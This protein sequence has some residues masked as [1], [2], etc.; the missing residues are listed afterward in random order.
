MKLT[1]IGESVA[2]PE[3]CWP[4]HRKVGTKPGTGKNAG[5]QVNDCEKI[6]E[7]SVAE[8]G[9]KNMYAEFSGYGNYMQGRAVNVF[10]T[11]GL[12]IVSK[13]YTEDDDI[14]TYVVK[15]DRQSIEKAGEYLER[16]AE[17]FG[18][19][20]FV[21]SGVT[22]N[23][24]K[25]QDLS[26]VSTEKLK[27]YL[28]KQGQQQGSGEGGQVKRVQA[29]LQR[30]SQ[31]VGE[32]YQFKGP[33][34]FDVDHMHGGRGINLPVADTRD[35]LQKPYEYYG[36]YKEWYR[37]VNRVNS[38]LLDDNAEYTTTAGGKTISINGKDFAAWSNRN[39]NGRI[40]IGIAKKHSGQG[41]AEMVGYNQGK[42]QALSFTGRKPVAKKNPNPFDKSPE[43]KKSQLQRMKDAGKK[44]WYA[45]E[46]QGVA[47]GSSTNAE[48]TKRAKAAA[49]KAGK[50]FNTDVEYRLWYAITTQANAATRKA[51]KKQ[52]VSEGMMDNPGEQDSPV[53]QAIIRRILLQRTDLLAKHGP[54]KVGQAV[55]E[56]AD[57]VGDVD[58]I[59][60][61][62]VSGWVR[63]V[64]QMLGN[65]GEGVAEGTDTLNVGDDVIITGAVKYKGATGVVDSVGRDGN[66][67]VVDLYN[68]GK[69]SFQSTDV[70]YNDYAG[71]E[72]EET[73]MQQRGLGESTPRSALGKAISSVK[74]I[75]EA[76]KGHTIEAHGVK[77][78]KN[79]VWR[80]TFKNA[81]QAT[82]WAEKNDAE[83]HG[84]RD[85][86]QAKKGNLSPA[87]KEGAKVDRMVKHIAKSERES[88]KS[89][90]EAEDIA[91]ATANKR[92]MLDNK[93]KKTESTEVRT[94][95][96]Y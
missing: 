57:F 17:Q 27:A 54:E 92:G 42:P 31:G 61:S 7:D 41:M 2:G 63:H 83:I 70:S 33:F 26:G 49:Q 43:D 44:N 65:M 73:E 36:N 80:K 16:N 62:D 93:N 69:Q 22:E 10:K 77:G 29:E 72:A 56:V 60:S 46:Q 39:G 4:G 91:W 64:E 50:T 71:S 23:Y 18:G 12:E 20:H 5:K 45:I 6:K 14:Q 34:P 24:P 66:F 75:S 85:L 11:A 9:F 8:G 53:A 38:E 58:E 95:K 19:Y 25:H 13:D 40:D 59:G 51:D 28:A 68:H 74:I 47:E 15:G 35:L 78:M 37:D 30:R 82:D 81:E 48:V 76:A 67:I 52:G 1:D 84:T 90:D 94:S 21:K 96:K 86:E 55:D 79:S 3:S 89:K 32:G 88:G 87:V